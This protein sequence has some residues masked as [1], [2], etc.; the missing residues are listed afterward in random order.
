MTEVVRLGDLISVKHG[1]AFP[2]S[3]FSDDPAYPTLVTPGNFAIGGGFKSSKP[4][5]FMDSYPADFVLRADDLVVSMTDLSREGATLGC[6]AMIPTGRRFLH[7]QRIGLVE[8]RDTSTLDLRFLNYFLRTDEY[9]KYVLATASGTTVRHTSPSRIE[10]FR[11]SIPLIAEQRAISSVL[12]A[13]DD[14]IAAN[15][16]AARATLALADSLFEQARSSNEERT[17]IGELAEQNIIEFGD[18]YRTKRSEH[19]KPGLRILRAGDVRDFQLLPAGDDYVSADYSRQVGGKA[20]KPG[21]VVM[22]TKGTVGRVAVVGAH[23]EQVVY[24]PQICYF[25]V[26]VVPVWASAVWRRGSEAQI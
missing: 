4:K 14:K 19:G 20:S 1:Y 9:R 22:T 11:A 16:R 17:T 24:S 10:D 18:G 6:P 25:R 21:D 13:L 7:N 26:R 8:I 23:T 5:T 2:G 3:G 15:E 12:G